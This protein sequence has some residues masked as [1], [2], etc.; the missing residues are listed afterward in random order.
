MYSLRTVMKSTQHTI[1]TFVS[2]ALALGCWVYTLF[3]AM[4]LAITH[5]EALSYLIF[6]YRPLAELLKP[7][8]IGMSAN[9]HLLNTLLAHFSV[10]QLG[11]TELAMRI[12][13]LCGAACYFLAC[14]LIAHGLFRGFAAVCACVLLLANPY[15]LDFMP[16]ARG[17]SLA[18]G[19]SMLGFWLLLRRINYT[20]NSGKGVR[21]GLWFSFMSAVLFGLAPFANLA[22]LN[23][24]LAACCC[25]LGI[26]FA[27]SI[28]T[29][30][31]N[32]PDRS[33]LISR[34]LLR[35]TALFVPSAAALLLVYWRPVALL[36][37]NKQFFFGGKQGFVRDTMTS[38][39][40]NWLYAPW[41]DS[42]NLVPV[43]WGA[44]LLLSLAGPASLLLAARRGKLKAYFNTMLPW[45][46]LLFALPVL[47]S[48]T[49]HLLLGT[50]FL[51]D[52]TALYFLPVTLLLLLCGLQTLSETETLT[53]SPGI[54]RR[55]NVVLA[56][57][58]VLALCHTLLVSTPGATRE[59]RY[60][61]CATTQ[62]EQVADIAFK[63]L[64]SG[65]LKAPVQVGTDYLLEPSTIFF[66]NK[67]QVKWLEW[68]TADT[69]AAKFPFYLGFTKKAQPF[70]QAGY[71]EFGGCAA[72]GSTIF[73]RADLSG[74]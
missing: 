55:G 71:T 73:L 34:H 25:L 31:E 21:S 8:I 50:R 39:F 24:F 66:I 64:R 41:F 1:A 36:Q 22:Y 20:K 17:Y 38:L 69:P 47:E 45:S 67:Y 59:W 74:R 61:A 46:W 54:R 51:L 27:H 60:N 68:Q 23:L 33:R 53:N 52:R 72:A 70:L 58:A 57:C 6:A 30:P 63:A 44:L 65:K 28:R 49:Q 3:R 40:H 14:V 42:V 12:P 26:E 7:E 13:A 37:Q 29:V 48:L 11:A 16:L 43:A 19:L 56:A 4:R 18:L 9:N 32:A 5:D 62:L 10:E 35:T 2:S 15:V